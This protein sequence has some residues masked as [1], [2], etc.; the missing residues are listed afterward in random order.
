MR[1]WLRQRLSY[2]NVMS[3]LC[4]FLLLGGVAYAATLPRNSVGTRQLKPR[5]VNNSDIR[6]NA[7]TSGKVRNG[8]LLTRDFARGVLRRGA[9]G[10]RGPTG[11]AGPQGP[12]G[13]GTGP[14]GGALAGSFPNPS[15]A[16]TGRGPAVAGARIAAAGGL[17]SYFNRRGGAPAVAHTPGTNVYTLTFGGSNFDADLPLATI[18]GNPGEIQTT[19][20]GGNV[21][22]TTYD[23][24][25]AAAE[26]AF[27]VAVF[28]ASTG[29]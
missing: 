13:A 17:Q 25:G 5:A 4:L 15:L 27:T 3:T 26:R 1:T 18:F 14:A 12:A 8:T 28:D 19:L 11:P 20:T 2:A 16:A 23:S 6:G 21:I 24:A 7:V 29:G 22:V 9:T 10:A